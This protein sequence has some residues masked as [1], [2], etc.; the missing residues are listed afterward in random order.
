MLGDLA[1]RP[2]G[3]SGLVSSFPLLAPRRS[4]F[5]SLKA[6]LMFLPPLPEEGAQSFS[7]V[8]FK[9]LVSV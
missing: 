4:I 8:A 5:S 6:T 3:K 1:M 2:R 7:H 9:V